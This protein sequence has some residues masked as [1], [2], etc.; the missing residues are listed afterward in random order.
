MANDQPDSVVKFF[1]SVS[2]IANAPLGQTV[3][4]FSDLVLNSIRVGVF[5]DICDY[6]RNNFDVLENLINNS[7]E[8]DNGFIKILLA[9]SDS[10]QFRLRLHIW[11]E[12]PLL[13]Q[14]IHD[15]RFDF[16]SSVFCGSL[17]N[18]E[19]NF[20]DDGV[21]MG[22]YLYF[23]RHGEDSYD[24]Q[25]NGE[26][27]LSC[28]AQKTINAGSSYLVE[29]STLHTVSKHGGKLITIFVEDRRSIKDYANVYS[30]R[31][32]KRSFSLSSPSITTNEYLRITGNFLEHI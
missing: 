24:L 14:N 18:I 30:V 23:P 29:K 20:K 12:S 22:H 11:P 21:Y 6:N 27:A 13:E 16:W 5:H 15:H 32:K 4:L 8:H 2:T 26:K 28:T 7:Y 25:W 1:H 9:K 17:T 31:Y 19:W 3:G 10:Q